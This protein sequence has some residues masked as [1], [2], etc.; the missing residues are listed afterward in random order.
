MFMAARMNALAHSGGFDFDVG[1]VNVDVVGESGCVDGSAPLVCI[2]QCRGGGGRGEHGFLLLF[3]FLEDL[4][5]L[6]AVRVAIW[7]DGKEVFH[8]SFRGVEEGRL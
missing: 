7:R 4:A 1:G 8:C 3:E 5:R 6:A 2:E